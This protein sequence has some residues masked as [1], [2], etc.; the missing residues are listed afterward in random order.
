[1]NDDS[2]L[3]DVRSFFASM[4]AAASGS[5]DPRL[6]R[7]FA[8][9]RREAFLPP[10]PWQ[11]M[12]DH[13]YLTTPSA[14]PIFLY[15][16]VLVALDAAR[17]INNG[18]P[19]LHAKWIGKTALQAGESVVHIGAGTGYYTALLA[20]LV[21][22]GGTVTAFELQPTLAA[23]AKQNLKPY[24]NVSVITGDAVMEAI[25]AADLIYVN[26]GVVA[27]PLSWMQALK[28]NGRMIL[29]WR[30]NSETGLAIMIRRCDDGFEVEPLMHAYFIPCVGASNA[31]TTQKTPSYVDAWRS[32]SIRLRATTAPDET[33]TAI[34]ADL[35]FS[36]RQVA[37]GQ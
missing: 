17:G 10:G 27:P 33:A 30:P 19:F 2:R 4:L 35:W 26:A 21:R 32:R 22:P 37:D 24:S 8:D 15:Q 29:P 31:A 5:S 11:I 20:E 13:C 25:P 12:V 9:V 1:M 16:N 28:P 7:I 34:Y 3:D 18:E 14:D 23:A 6:Q 36:S